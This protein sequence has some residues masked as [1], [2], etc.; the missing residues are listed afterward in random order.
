MNTGSR[1]FVLGPDN[2][3]VRL[4]DGQ[5]IP[6]I[7]YEQ[8]T[9]AERKKQK[10]ERI[11]QILGDAATYHSVDGT[12]S[13]EGT[14]SG[15]GGSGSFSFIATDP[16]KELTAKR[17]AELVIDRNHTNLEAQRSVRAVSRNS[18]LRD[19]TVDPNAIYGGMAK[20]LVTDPIRKAVGSVPL[21]VE[22]TVQGEQHTFVGQLVAIK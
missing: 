18:L 22:V 21:I 12:S 14:Y 7:T 9:A 19:T 3:K 15:S 2:I 8:A 17:E 4:L 10:R 5:L 13:G 16:G 1:P 11:W 6:L 20:L